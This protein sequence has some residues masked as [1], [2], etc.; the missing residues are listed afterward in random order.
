MGSSFSAKC[1]NCG[2]QAGGLIGGGMRD[3]IVF[4]SW[5]ALCLSCEEITTVNLNVTPLQ[6]R[7]CGGADVTPYLEK[8]ASLSR[9]GPYAKCRKGRMRDGSTY[10]IDPGDIVWGDLTL[11]T[12]KRYACPKCRSLSV[13]FSHGYMLWD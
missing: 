11:D 9:P 2:Y 8:H 5:P 7:K 4:C 1:E 12:L 13:G 3:H 6:C 10:D